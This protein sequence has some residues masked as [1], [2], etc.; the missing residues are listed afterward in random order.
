MLC[1][2]IFSDLEW[3][4]IGVKKFSGLM[5]TGGNKGKIGKIRDL[6]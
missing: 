5:F 3:L 2:R 4:K 6:N 1:F